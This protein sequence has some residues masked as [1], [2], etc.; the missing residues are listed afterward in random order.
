M[1]YCNFFFL[2]KEMMKCEG[3]QVCRRKGYKMAESCLLP[4]PASSNSACWNNSAIGG[5]G[6][7]S[8]ILFS[9]TL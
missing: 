3:W 5:H 7:V 8:P 6:I 1:I 9:K 4:R 2:L